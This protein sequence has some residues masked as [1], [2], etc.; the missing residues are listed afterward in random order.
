[1]GIIRKV[2]V[3]LSLMLTIL[4]SSSAFADFNKYR[5]IVAN[6]MLQKISVNTKEQI[7]FKHIEF[8]GDVKN[9]LIELCKSKDTDK[10]ACEIKND[11]EL[12][13]GFM[14]YGNLYQYSRRASAQINEKGELNGIHIQSRIDAYPEFIGLLTEKYGKPLTVQAGDVKDKND[15]RH[16]RQ[17]IYWND[18]NGTVIA[19]DTFTEAESNGYYI[20]NWGEVNIM[21]KTFI[22][23]VTESINN[24]AQSYFKNEEKRKNYNLNNL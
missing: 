20:S 6:M 1:M 11:G 10:G 12:V 19:I 3:I 16:K 15:K 24:D 13:L 18:S 23:I 5:P 8:K 4:A 2:P 14:E 21:S 17:Q 22:D 9:Q 7:K